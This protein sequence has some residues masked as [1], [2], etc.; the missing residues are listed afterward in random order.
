MLRFCCGLAAPLAK[1]DILAYPVLMTSPT[2]SAVRFLLNGLSP[3]CVAAPP[4][5]TVLQWLRTRRRLT[6]TKEGCAEGDCGACTVVVGE[7]ENGALT[8]R[9]VNACIMMMGQLH[10]RLLVTVEGLADGE[11][12]HPVQ[13]AMIERHASQC[14]FCTP[15]FVMSLFAAFRSGEAPQ[16]QTIHDSIAG[17]LCRCTGYRPIVEAAHDALGAGGQDVYSAQE[18]QILAALEAIAAELDLI[19]ETPEGRFHAPTTKAALH[20]AL[21]ADPHARLISGG[22]DLALDVTKRHLRLPSLLS[23][24]S[25]PA[26]RRIEVRDDEIVAG[27]AA[28][29]ADLLSALTLIDE[30]FAVLLRRLGSRQIRS[31]GTIGGNLANASPIGDTPPA[32][33]ALGA[34]VRIDGVNGAREISLDDFYT[35]YRRTVLQPGEYIESVAIPRPGADAFFRVDK[36]SRRFDQDISAVCGAFSFIRDGERIMAPRVAF[37]GMAATPARAKRTEEALAGAIFSNETLAQAQAAMAQDFAP[38]SDFRA[39]A[40]YR[41]RTAQNLLAR[42]RLAAMGLEMEAAQ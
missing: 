16:T 34:R 12:L 24:G 26:M 21:R 17:N 32:L 25:I 5:M 3:V 40:D 2:N 42:W 13:S 8:W 22:T 11:A 29:Y 7:A 39:S 4:D 28:P 30:S 14:G 27:A 9:P 33:L 36:I 1:D 38:I 41:L 35:G 23:L 6:G 15:G 18:P 20:A 10:G 31:L 37:G 19:C